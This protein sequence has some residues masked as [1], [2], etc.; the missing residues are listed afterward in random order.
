MRM[1]VATRKVTPKEWRTI[2]RHSDMPEEVRALL[3]HIKDH[4]TAVHDT[5]AVQ[6]TVDHAN[7][8]F[9]EVDYLYRVRKVICADWK[10][11]TNGRFGLVAV[12]PEEVLA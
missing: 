9:A 10:K 7:Q 1:N 12:V 3:K 6:K 8:F 11:R 4:G 2:L 5:V